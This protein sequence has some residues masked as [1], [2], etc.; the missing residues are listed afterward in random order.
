MLSLSVSLM[1]TWEALSST[2]VS[3]LVSGGPQALVYGLIIS[4]VGSLA[5]AA[6]LAEMAS[7]FPTPGGQYH[8]IAY[9]APVRMRIASSWIAGWITTFGWITVAASA[10]FLSGTMIQGLVVLNHQTYNYQRWHGTLIYWAILTVSDFT[11]VFGSRILPMVEN[12]S[13]AFHIGAFVAVLVVTCVVSPVRHDASFVFIE[14]VNNSG[15]SNSAVAWC[16]GLLSSCNVLVGYDGAIHLSEE[17][18]NPRIHVPTAMLGSIIINAMMGFGF[19][20]AILFHMGDL[21]ASLQTATGFPIIQIFLDITGNIHAATALCSTVVIMAGLSSIPLLASS[22]RMM[23]VLARDE[24]FPFPRLLSRMDEK[25]QIPTNAVHFT[26]LL[27]ALLG[28]LNIASTTAFNAV[29]SLAVFGL[30]LSYLL[31][32]CFLLYRRMASTEPL[33][34]GPWTMGRLGLP[35]NLISVC[36]LGFTCMFLVFPPYQPV[37]PENMNYAVVVFG[38]VCVVSGLYWFVRGRKVYKGPV[39]PHG[40]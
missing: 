30:Q 11:N 2:M 1:A 37:T 32:I 23:W 31:P 38:A 3:G 5:T 34:Y 15:W 21:E 36:Y 27:L 17:M 19:L 20:M 24:A 22:S 13:L 7:M 16:V 6:S 4:F 28:L 33:P 35:I 18:K 9:L 10:P 14:T 26:S 12:L 29:T 40:F 39:A 25:R 8:Y